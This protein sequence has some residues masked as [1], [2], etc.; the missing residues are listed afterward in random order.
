MWLILAPG[1]WEVLYNHWFPMP[2]IPFILVLPTSC[3]KE[4]ISRSCPTLCDPMAPWN[5]P[6]KNPGVGCHSLLQGIFP[7]QGFN[8]GLLRCRRILYCL[9]HQGGS[10]LAALHTVP[11]CLHAKLLQSCLTLCDRMDH[12][13]PGYS[14]YGILQARTLEWVAISTSRGSFQPRFQTRVSYV[15]C[16]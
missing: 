10:K 6:G 3:R 13:P 11:A 2:A 1:N 8:L 4:S 7:T 12:S 16:I 15:S 5:S 14:V 9:N